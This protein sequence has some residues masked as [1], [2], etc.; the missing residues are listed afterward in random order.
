MA[1]SPEL[2]L[3]QR[4]EDLAFTLGWMQGHSGQCWLLLAVLWGLQLQCPPFSPSEL[5]ASGW[6]ETSTL[7][8]WLSCLAWE[9]LRLSRASGLCGK[10]DGSGRERD[11]SGIM[12]AIWEP[13]R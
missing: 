13:A 6:P 2:A 9:E 4:G 7:V 8:S 10:E 3:D 5:R 12:A 11:A 1:G